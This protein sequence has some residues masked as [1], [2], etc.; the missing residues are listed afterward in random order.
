MVDQ[1]D[2][3]NSPPNND[4]EDNNQPQ[5]PDA[6]V[7]EAEHEGEEDEVPVAANEAAEVSDHSDSETEPTNEEIG[8]KM[9]A[10]CGRRSREGLRPRRATNCDKHLGANDCDKRHFFTVESPNN[11]GRIKQRLP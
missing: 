4:Q 10:A 2:E 1:H 3:N 11:K 5:G 6:I 9:D 8:N 7:E